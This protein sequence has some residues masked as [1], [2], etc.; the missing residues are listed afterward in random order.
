MSRIQTRKIALE[1]GETTYIGSVC[2]KHSTLGGKR[3]TNDGNCVACTLVKTTKW[4]EENSAKFKASQRKWYAA[5]RN[6]Q[7]AR[8]KGFREANPELIKNIQA[9]YGRKNRD[10]IN[11]KTAKRNAAKLSATPTWGNEF[12]IKEAYHLAK[13]REKML[14]GKWHVDHIVPLQSKLV[15]GLHVENN[16]QVIPQF[17]NLSKN[18]N[19][20]PNM[21]C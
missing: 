21:P 9:T 1:G 15:C 6:E 7:I 11:A 5:N 8:C 16:L 19:H 17:A 10:K 18:N 3:N 20:W 4:R 13:I 2:E 14:G 12:F